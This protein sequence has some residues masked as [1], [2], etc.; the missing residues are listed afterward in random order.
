MLQF[1]IHNKFGLRNKIFYDCEASIFQPDANELKDHEDCR[2]VDKPY[3]HFTRM[4]H[5]IL[6]Y[7]DYYRYP[8]EGN[9]C[10][11]IYILIMINKRLYY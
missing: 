2:L 6:D 9:I 11:Y 8:I 5:D 4:S 10:I 7:S 1:I 3:I